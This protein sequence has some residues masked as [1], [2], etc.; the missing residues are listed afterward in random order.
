[1]GIWIQAYK[2]GSALSIKKKFTIILTLCMVI[3]FIVIITNFRCI[4]SR[5]VENNAETFIEKLNQIATNVSP[6]MKVS[7]FTAIIIK[8]IESE[9]AFQLLFMTGVVNTM[10]A[11]L[12]L[13][14][15]LLIV[16]L[17][18]IQREI[19]RPLRKL[20][21]AIQTFNRDNGYHSKAHSR[22]EIK[23]LTNN[24]YL[25]SE[26]IEVNKKRKNELIS[27]ISH[28]LK[29]PLTS[30]LGYTQRLINPGIPEEQKR[31]KYYNT[32][33]TKAA[34]MDI[35][36]DELN[37]YVMDEVQ[38]VKLEAVNLSV[39]INGIV[40]EY[41]EEL[42]TYNI[43]LITEIKLYDE[44]VC[45]M[46]MNGMRRVFANL[47]ANAVTHGGRDIIISLKAS[48]ENKKLKVCMENNG[49]ELVNNEYEK[50]F[51]LLY[52]ADSAR[53][54][55][56]KGKGLG[57]ALVKQIIDKHH[58]EIKAYK[59]YGGGFGIIFYIPINELV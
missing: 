57:L 10:K 20:N 19:C 36:V 54:N 45:K 18:Y 22:N 16:L 25:M 27:Y 1:M 9:E 35:M 46:D 34:D 33:L 7:E 30:I 29:T 17:A 6:D 28:D 50:I 14:A 21:E 51:E 23:E 2:G 37:T 11:S 32:I 8:K 3:N 4:I 52:Q 38:Q 44:S 53:T 13:L 49:K 12:V 56:R 59:P 41:R 39:F 48:V 15:V 26:Q 42:K 31:L 47:F 43:N 55:K 40:E 58:G 5:E 24:F